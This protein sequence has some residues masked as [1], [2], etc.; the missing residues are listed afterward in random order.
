MRLNMFLSAVVASLAAV[1]TQAIQVSVQ[2]QVS[3]A[4]ANI[5][6]KDL[7]MVGALR[8]GLQAIK[9]FPQKSASP[10]EDDGDLESQQVAAHLAQVSTSDKTHSKT[11]HTS[12]AD[13]YGERIPD[14]EGEYG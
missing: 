14:P 6:D 8:A 4:D 10:V 5:Y 7:K 3:A 13:L 2:A 12:T 1:S 11:A 9:S